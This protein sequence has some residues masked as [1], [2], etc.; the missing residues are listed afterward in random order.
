MATTNKKLNVIE[1][2]PTW[3]TG[4]QRRRI[5]INSGTGKRSQAW[6]NFRHEVDPRQAIFDAIGKIPAEVVQLARI[7]IAVYQPPLATKSSGGIILTE[8][9]TDDDLNE[10]LWQGK[11]GLIVAAGP[12]A[13]EDDES[14]KFHGTKNVVGDWVWFHPSDGRALE[15]NGVFCRVFTEAGIIGKLP[16]PD[17]VW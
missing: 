14:T 8:Q 6:V 16:D 4:L 13:Y 7:L 10:Y 11:V 17:S 5:T 9:T 2:K 3:N 1:D 15:V 12:Q